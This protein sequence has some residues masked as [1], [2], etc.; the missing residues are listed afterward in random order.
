[1]VTHEERMAIMQE[2]VDWLRSAPK[3]ADFVPS[4]NGVGLAER[5]RDLTV[6]E[7]ADELEKQVKSGTA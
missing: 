3:V 1:M 5:K 7:A 4:N 2:V 6:R